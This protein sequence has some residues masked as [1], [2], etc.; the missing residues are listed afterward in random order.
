MATAIR[1]LP[2]VLQRIVKTTKYFSR[3]ANSA[4]WHELLKYDAFSDA[5]A[6]L[7]K[8]VAIDSTN[9]Q[10]A[11][12]VGAADGRDALWSIDL[13]DKEPPR[14]VFSHPLA[15][16]QPVFAKDG[17]LLGVFYETDLPHMFYT[18]AHASL[19][20]TAL[21]KALPN[22]LLALV[23]STADEKTFVVR[24]SSDVDEGS[25]YIFDTAAGSLVAIGRAYPDLDP[26][27]LARM[28]TI[29][30]PAS[31][32]TVIPGYLTVP[33]GQRAER[34][35][36]VVMPH[37][38]PIARDSWDFFFLREFLTDRGYAVLQMNFR[39]SDGYGNK[40]YADAHQ[41][42]GGLTYSDIADG[43]RWAIKSGIADPKRVCIVGWSFGGYAALL[44]AVRDSAMYRC[45]ASIAGVSDLSLMLQEESNYTN[46]AFAREQVGTKVEKL[47][48][49]SPRRHADD[50]KIPILMVH[51]DRDPQ[52][53]YEQ[54]EAMAKALKKA[55]KPFEFIT[56]K[57]A[58]HQIAVPQDRLKLLT[59]VETFLL[60]NLGPG[61]P[62]A[63]QK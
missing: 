60:Q 16:V 33:V 39:G 26:V 8:P 4:G 30:Y 36:L 24:A 25:Y 49:D 14:L 55:G 40:W 31:D 15:D 17:R 57:N 13:T 35:P 44:G 58:D 50:V 20:A 1:V 22:K 47:R 21:K 48:A 27:K 41:D 3:D 11:Y 56:L 43:A 2:R 12:A 6:T 29:S 59:A 37:G 28:Q 23:D 38:G 7:A 18:D 5:S 45:A 42:W 9:P 51:G 46:S 54:S 32:G 53:Y 63:P 52:A 10:R 61:V 19:V 62:P 34:L